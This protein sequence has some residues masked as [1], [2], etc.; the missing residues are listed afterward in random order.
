MKPLAYYLSLPWTVVREE[1]S[2]DGLYIALTIAELPGFV[3]AE[4]DEA[5]LEREFWP[6]LTAFV[7]AYLREGRE[8][9]VPA[10]APISIAF[11]EL[12]DDPAVSQISAF[13][14]E[15]R[16]QQSISF[17]SSVSSRRELASC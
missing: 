9:P 1:H 2:D 7:G 14:E 11:K 5:E 4:R 17:G 15:P 16:P 10:G 3:V 12:T 13:R 8:P 6:A